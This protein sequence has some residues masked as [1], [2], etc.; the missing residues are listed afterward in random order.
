MAFTNNF[1]F[2]TAVSTTYTIKAGASS[3][4]IRLRTSSTSA[5]LLINHPGG[6]YSVTLNGVAGRLNFELP[7]IPAQNYPEIDL[8]AIG[9]VYIEMIY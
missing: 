5:T 3:I 9:T 2:H 6:V 7:P 4:S 8:T 1:V